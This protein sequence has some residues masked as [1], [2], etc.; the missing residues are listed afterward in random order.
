MCM[1]SAFLTIAIV[2]LLAVMSPGPDFALVVQH[3]LG[4]SQRVGLA[5]AAG[6]ALGI[7]VHTA[8]SLLGIGFVIAQSILLFNA[9]K[10][11]G[12]AYLIWIGL[13]ALFSRKPVANAAQKIERAH[14]TTKQAVLRGFLCNV[15]NPKATLFFLAVFTQVIDPATPLPVQLFY[16]AFMGCSTF[17]WFGFVACTLNIAMIKRR[18]AF[19]QYRLERAMGAVLI[20]L[21]LKIALSSKQ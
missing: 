3:S 20:A 5:T 17:L 8:Y 9:I 16:G 6:I 14:L 13:K 10:F 18:F 12:A 19:I 21:G 2:H 1:M 4:Q 15:L 7:L 11:L